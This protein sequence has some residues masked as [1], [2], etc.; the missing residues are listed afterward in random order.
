MA[1]AALGV[2]VF[3]LIGCRVSSSWRD[4]RDNRLG[5]WWGSLGLPLLAFR[6]RRSRLGDTWFSDIRCCWRS[7][8]GFLNCCRH[9]RTCERLWLGSI[10]RRY[11]RDFSE[12]LLNAFKQQLRHIFDRDGVGFASGGGA[13]QH[14]LAEGAA[15]S[16]NL[17]FPARERLLGLPVA[18]V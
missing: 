18:I 10:D 4:C 1:A 5:F 12:F 3:R 8:D 2:Q 13:V 17:I 16:E 14:A 6:Y 9:Q 11:R 15:D 7:G